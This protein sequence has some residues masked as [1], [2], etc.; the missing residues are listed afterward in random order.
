MSILTSLLARRGNW[1]RLRRRLNMAKFT[2]AGLM[3][4]NRDDLL[5]LAK[6]IEFVDDE[7]TKSEISDAIIIMEDYRPPSVSGGE[8][9][10]AKSETAIEP[11]PDDPDFPK[12]VRVRRIEASQNL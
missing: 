6:D 4:K 11:G 5:E 1:H 12:S 9:E 10:V 2:K 7:M 3:R 8:V